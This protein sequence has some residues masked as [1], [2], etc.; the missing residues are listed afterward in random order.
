MNLTNDSSEKESYLSDPTG[1]LLADL[2]SFHGAQARNTV[3]FPTT[4]NGTVPYV[5]HATKNALMRTMSFTIIITSEQ[6]D[7]SPVVGV[8]E[9][10]DLHEYIHANFSKPICHYLKIDPEFDAKIIADQLFDRLVKTDGTVLFLVRYKK[11]AKRIKN[12]LNTKFA[13]KKIA[14]LKHIEDYGK[15]DVK[16]LTEHL[17]M[18]DSIVITRINPFSN[19]LIKYFEI[20]S[21]ISSLARYVIILESE[22]G[23]VQLDSYSVRN[24]CLNINSK[25]V[26]A[27]TAGI[28]DLY[29]PFFKMVDIS[30]TA[31]E[32]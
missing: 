30:E 5:Y 21:I 1:I 17:E 26:V 8:A 2:H 24:M 11:D 9:D 32:D 15:F 31:P 29:R 4:A 7:Y 14:C 25:I 10:L 16:R 13:A 3:I 6:R 18:K 23:Q 22:V 12:V 19:L 20:S 27:A 28:M